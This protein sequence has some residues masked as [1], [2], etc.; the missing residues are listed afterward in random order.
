MNTS[1]AIKAAGSA[2][3]VF[4]F[5]YSQG[6]I[7]AVAFLATAILLNKLL[8]PLETPLASL[9]VK[10]VTMAE[11]NRLTKALLST[12]DAQKRMIKEMQGIMQYLNIGVSGILATFIAKQLSS[13]ADS[14]SELFQAA[15]NV[16]PIFG[17]SVM[18]LTSITMVYMSV[19]LFRQT[20]N[21]FNE[22]NLLI[23]QMNRARYY[24]FNQ[25]APAA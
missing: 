11:K 4:Y 25:N 7:S 5:A 1:F 17:L 6:P 15:I 21:E 9:R 16:H 3:G 13:G 19:V 22:G 10:Q 18:L 24:I 2:C 12:P 8:S 23:E 20:I 14:L